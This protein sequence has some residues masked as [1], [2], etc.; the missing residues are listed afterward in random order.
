MLVALIDC[1]SRPKRAMTLTKSRMR[2]MI[3]VRGDVEDMERGTNIGS[4][5]CGSLEDQ[6]VELS[7]MADF[8]TCR[9][10]QAPLQVIRPPELP[11]LPH[12]PKEW[13][14]EMETMGE[15]LGLRTDPKNATFSPPTSP[16]PTVLTSIPITDEIRPNRGDLLSDPLATRDA[17]G[18]VYVSSNNNNKA[19]TRIGGDEKNPV[20][21]NGGIYL[22][23]V[24]QPT[25]LSPPRQENHRATSKKVLEKEPSANSSGHRKH[26]HD[27]HRRDSHS[28]DDHDATDNE[29]PSQTNQE[30]SSMAVLPEEQEPL[31]EV[32]V[33]DE[34]GRTST[35]V[36]LDEDSISYY[37]QR[38]TAAKR[39]SES[40]PAVAPHHTNR[41]SADLRHPHPSHQDHHYQHRPRDQLT[42][43]K[44]GRP[45]AAVSGAVSN[46]MQ[47]NQ[48]RQHHQQPLQRREERPHHHQQQQ[49]QQRKHRP[50]S[51][52]EV[53]NTTTIS[54]HH[55]Y[56]QY[57]SHVQDTD[58]VRAVA[59]RKN[60]DE[61]ATTSSGLQHSMASSTIPPSVTNNKNNNVRIVVVRRPQQIDVPNTI[62]HHGNFSMDESREYHR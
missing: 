35:R 6:F 41:R 33:D 58:T 51:V 43:G 7:T 24:V 31:L 15:F 37:K 8:V 21:G 50:Y 20:I 44:S 46:S 12:V 30:V 48:Q 27:D 25:A 10:V 23:R 16:A 19:T 26:R 53:S 28:L 40:P 61:N 17:F 3:E 14:V 1:I 62:H 49:Q 13:I 56:R 42:G 11:K 4:A 5:S 2:P 38:P 47:G 54:S 34:S 22:C 32:I 39:R 57:Y 52:A 36:V 18:N 55:P 29:S 45:A 60:F 59:P 9:D